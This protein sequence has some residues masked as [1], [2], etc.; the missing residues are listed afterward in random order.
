MA[1][2]DKLNTLASAAG[3]KASGAIE[4]GKLNLRLGAEERKIEAITY[5]L[6]ACLLLN[7]EA[8]QE[9]DETIM[10]LFE[11]VKTSRAMIGSIRGEIATL[12][13]IV[14]CPTCCSKNT[15]DS[16][17][18]RECGSK[19]INQEEAVI[20]AE[21]ISKLCP[22]CGQAVDTQEQFCTQCGNRLH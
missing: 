12:S 18:C 1:F 20:E 3:E 9:Y 14:L 21:V 8:G 7:L 15:S 19:M 4:V 16:K 22:A 6:G 10:T 2:L 13:G 17:F 5:Q 11:E